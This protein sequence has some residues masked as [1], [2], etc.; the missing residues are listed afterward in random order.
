MIRARVRNTGSSFCWYFSQIALTDSASM[1]ACAGS[2]TPHG[3]SQWA[4]A[5]VAGRVQRTESE[6]ISLT[7]CGVVGRHGRIRNRHYYRADFPLEGAMEH[8]LPWQRVHV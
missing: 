6:R 3:R 4:N 7:S 2:Y 8:L 1:R 5:T